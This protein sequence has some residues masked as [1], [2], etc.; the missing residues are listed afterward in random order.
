MLLS[1]YVP[2]LVIP[3]G[4]AVDMGSRLCKIVN[5]AQAVTDRKK[6]L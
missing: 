4:M 1:S 2:F 5:D 3:L 6:I